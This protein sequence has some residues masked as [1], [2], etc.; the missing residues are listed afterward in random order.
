MKTIILSIV[1]SVLTFCA[2]AQLS[3]NQPARLQNKIT[4][5]EGKLGS[6]IH[7]SAILVSPDSTCPGNGGNDNVTS[8]GYEHE[9]KSQASAINSRTSTGYGYRWGC[10]GIGLLQPVLPEVSAQI[11]LRSESLEFGTN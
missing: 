1:L 5:Y 3:T 6:G 2:S 9:L 10:P 8:P 11:R 7:G 4:C